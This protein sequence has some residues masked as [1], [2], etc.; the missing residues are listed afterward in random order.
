[1]VSPKSKNK[2][3]KGIGRRKPKN[4]YQLTLDASYILELCDWRSLD[5]EDE[6]VKVFPRYKKVITDN[7]EFISYLL[8]QSDITTGNEA[9]IIRENINKLSND[10]IEKLILY[11]GSELFPELYYHSRS[12]PD[13]KIREGC[14]RQL[15]KILAIYLLARRESNKRISINI[16]NNKKS[17]FNVP[18]QYISFEVFRRLSKSQ[19][20][21]INLESETVMK[22]LLQDFQEDAEKITGGEFHPYDRNSNTKKFIDTWEENKNEIEGFYNERFYAFMKCKFDKI[23]DHN[24]LLD[25][26]NW[27]E[28]LAY[29]PKK[30]KG[31]LENEFGKKEYKPDKSKIPIVHTDIKN[32][33]DKP[34]SPEIPLANP[35]HSEYDIEYMVNQYVKI[36]QVKT[37][38]VE[39]IN[40][41]AP[42]ATKQKKVGE[43][44]LSTDI[45]K[46]LRTSTKKGIDIGLIS[47]DS[48]INLDTVKNFI[49]GINEL[50][51]RKFSHYLK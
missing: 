35:K 19:F 20:P 24:L 27:D 2:L 43:F 28:G 9:E 11:Y 17:N 33:E 41:L 36:G 5:H 49:K 14:T 13:K 29:F 46:Y 40:T 50:A 30:F 10:N 16:R 37:I 42:Q 31:D 3:K 25:Q 6:V 1:M 8:E 51:Q 32:E 18:Q 12:C 39:Y 21:S 4:Y 45:I 22:L 34:I 47:G 44:L 23:T 7:A 26:Y 48:G 38:I 15:F